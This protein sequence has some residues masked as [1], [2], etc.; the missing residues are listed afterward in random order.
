MFGLF[1]WIGNEALVH[2]FWLEPL[3]LRCYSTKARW[4]E[5]RQTGLLLLD[6]PVG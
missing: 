1:G 2:G 4:R 3:Q 5:Y 6:L